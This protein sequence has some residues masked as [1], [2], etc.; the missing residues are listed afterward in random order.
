MDLVLHDAQAERKEDRP[1]VEV[2]RRR[3]GQE[4]LRVPVLD[5]GDERQQPGAERNQKMGIGYPTYILI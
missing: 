5:A 4:E 3:R 2:R 1:A